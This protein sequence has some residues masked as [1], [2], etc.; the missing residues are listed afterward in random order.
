MTSFQHFNFHYSSHVAAD[1][2]YLAVL[3]VLNIFLVSCTLEAQQMEIQIG[4]K[5]FKLRG[6]LYH[7]EN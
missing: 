7:G 6:K 4:E 2:T 3:P 1:I 5:S